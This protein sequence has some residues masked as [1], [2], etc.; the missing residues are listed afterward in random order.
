MFFIAVTRKKIDD[1]EQFA[2]IKELRFCSRIFSILTDDFLS[3]L[4]V[5]EDG[6]SIVESPLIRCRD[7]GGIIFSEVRFNDAEKR[8]EIHRSTISGR[9]IYYHINSKGDFYCSTH[10]R[11]LRDVGVKIEENV[12]VLPEY[13]VYRYV[14]P[15]NTLYKGIKQLSAG[16]RLKIRLRGGSCSIYQSEHLNP[17]AATAKVSGDIL[18]TSAAGTVDILSNLCQRLKRQ[19]DKI[20]FLLSGGLDSSILL[21]ICQTVFDTETTYSAGYPFENPEDNR[22]RKYAFSAAQVFGTQHKYYEPSTTEYL[23]GILEA[24]SVAEEP[25]HHLQSALLYLFLRNNS[26][27]DERIVINGL[28]ADGVF[29]STFQ[30]HLFDNIR[31]KRPWWVSL[32]CQYPLINL[33]KALS[34]ITGKGKGFLSK[35]YYHCPGCASLA[36]IDHAAWRLGEYGDTEWALDYFGVSTKD[37]IANRYNSIKFYRGRSVLD[38]TSLLSFLGSA[39]VTQAIWSKLGEANGKIVFYPFT[40][41]ELIQQTFQVPWDIKLSESKGILREAGRQLSIPEHIISRPKSGWGVCSERWGEKDGVFEPFVPLMAKVFDEKQI[42]L[43]QSSQ[44][45]KA[46]TFWNILNYAI[47]KRLCI[48]NEPLELLEKEL[49]EAIAN[50]KSNSNSLVSIKDG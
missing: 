34:M 42:R 21:K 24:I 10:I 22:E 48:N 7:F 5:T 37:F 19:D 29:G 23:L 33:L 44:E 25:L 39:S 50:D 12:K 46:M 35:V 11:M 45:Q 4:I 47:W 28:G 17:P 20:L 2:G 41:F 9:P 31:T 14:M 32:S 18:E 38:V 15:P 36:D 27:S 1:V 16:S 3:K 26:Q 30:R 49:L 43:M 6:F 40:D 8:L 13:F